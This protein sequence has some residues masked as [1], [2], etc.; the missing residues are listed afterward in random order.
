MSTIEH[1]NDAGLADFLAGWDK[2]L[3][4]AG[5]LPVMFAV[6]GLTNF[7]EKPVPSLRLAE[8]LGRP[9]SEA[10][11]LAQSHPFAPGTRVEDGL[12]RVEHGLIPFT[13][14]H[15]TSAPRRRLRIGDRRV[16]VTGCAPDVVLYAPLIRPSV[17]VEET[18]PATGTPMRFVFTPG[19]VESVDP[20]GAMVPILPPQAFDR[21]AG[22]PGD[23]DATVCAQCPFYSSAAAAQGWLATHPD[24]RVFPVREAWDLSFHREWAAQNVSP[25][26]PRQL[27]TG[28]PAACGPRHRRWCLAAEPAAGPKRQPVPG[29]PTAAVRPHPVRV[30]V[31]PAL[32]RGPVQ[33]GVQL[34]D[35]ARVLL[36]MQRRGPHSR[37][38]SFGSRFTSLR[39]R[40]YTRKP[41]LHGQTRCS[42]FTRTWSSGERS[43]ASSTPGSGRGRHA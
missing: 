40:S 1:G 43:S 32:L 4:K 35:Q 24:G 42:A 25:A 36:G 20:A 33:P 39:N 3:H 23:W 15:A 26:E 28:R 6:M 5:H 29:R 16:G 13:P 12:I 41:A 2:S 7:G 38:G 30:A 8:V 19:G 34:L 37:L 18:C 22:Y 21:L 9:V 14:E 27:T 11:A 10:G 17:Q 31:P